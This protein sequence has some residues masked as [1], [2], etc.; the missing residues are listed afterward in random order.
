MTPTERRVEHLRFEHN[1]RVDPAKLDL[2]GDILCAGEDAA[3]A[4]C[5]RLLDSWL[6]EDAQETRAPQSR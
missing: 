4:D 5:K 3:C 6:A 2:I 1:L